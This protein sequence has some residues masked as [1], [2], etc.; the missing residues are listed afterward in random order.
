MGLN[1]DANPD[2]RKNLLVYLTVHY[3]K[4]VLYQHILQ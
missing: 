2:H 4:F 1:L 3:Q